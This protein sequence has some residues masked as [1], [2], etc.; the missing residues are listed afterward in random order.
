M[1]CGVDRRDGTFVV[2]G[3]KGKDVEKKVTMYQY[4]YS[5]GLPSRELPNLNQGRRDHSCTHVYMGG[6]LVGNIS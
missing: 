1:S 2:I 5:Y 3:G 6:K 4:Q